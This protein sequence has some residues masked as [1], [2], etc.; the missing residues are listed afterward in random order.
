MR[1]RQPASVPAQKVTFSASACL[2]RLFE[3]MMIE[4]KLFY[5]PFMRGGESPSQDSDATT[6]LPPPLPTPKR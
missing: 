3:I 6:S 2:H 1:T 4:M 5:P